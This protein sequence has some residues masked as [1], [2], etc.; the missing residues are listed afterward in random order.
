MSLCTTKQWWAPRDKA[1]Q[2]QCWDPSHQAAPVAAAH[3]EVAVAPEGAGQQ[4][5]ADEAVD[6]GRTGSDGTLCDPGRAVHD[7]GAARRN[8]C[9]CIVVGWSRRLVS[10]TTSRSPVSQVMVGP[11]DCPLIV[12]VSR[13]F[14]PS[15][16][17]SCQ[18]TVRL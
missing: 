10:Q 1:A 2:K 3:L 17:A 8:P 14:T 11:G 4:A 6:L 18:A 15:G 12:I 7:V 9:Q 13:S 5:A 16:A